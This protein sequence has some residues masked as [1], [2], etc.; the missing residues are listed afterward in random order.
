MGTQFLNVDL[1]IRARFD[2]SALVKLLE[3]RGLPC[4]DGPTAKGRYWSATFETS[5]TRP[6]LARATDEFL[7][8]IEGLEAEDRQL[9]DRCLK[10]ELDFGYECQGDQFASAH[11]ISNDLIKRI[12]R[13]GA[14]VRTTI[15]RSTPPEGIS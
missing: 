5:L 8:V 7:K 4:I 1:V 12:G 3:E 10:K 15:Y 9:W 2:L 14:S 13:T 6:T 11:I